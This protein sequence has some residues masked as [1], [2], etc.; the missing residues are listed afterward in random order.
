MNNDCRVFMF[1]SSPRRRGTRVVRLVQRGRNRFIPAQAGNTAQICSSHSFTSVHPRAGGEHREMKQKALP[2]Y[3]SSPRRRGTLTV[4]LGPWAAQR[5]IPAQAGNT[6]GLARRRKQST[7]HP[8][9]GG[10]HNAGRRFFPHGGGSSPRRRGTLKCI[11]CF[12][13]TGRF[14][15]AQ[16]GNT[17]ACKMSRISSPVHPRAGGEHV[18]N[19]WAAKP[20]DGSSPRR[21]G[22]QPR[23]EGGARGVRFIPAQA[24]NTAAWTVPASNTSVHPRAGGEH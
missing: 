1:G 22:T 16:A 12:A 6:R 14:I 13:R 24:G 10:E 23:H 2:V 8:R 21:R 20:R 15:P 4:I 7:V 17:Q 9:A 3:G 5:F 11:E 18:S 19:T